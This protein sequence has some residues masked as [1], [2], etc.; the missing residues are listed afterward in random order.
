MK[1]KGNFKDKIIVVVSLAV[2]IISVA[3]LMPKSEE[4]KKEI[5]EVVVLQKEVKENQ[6]IEE[7]D[8]KVV[9]VG[10]YNLPGEV[11]TKKEDAIG[12]YAVTTLK[13]GRYIYKGDVKNEQAMSSY[14]YK[15]KEDSIS[16]QTDLAKCVGG[17]P[18]QG[19]IVRVWIYEKGDMQNT[20]ETK[21]EN[22]PILAAMKLVSIVNSAGAPVAKTTDGK[23]YGNATDKTKPAVVTVL[24][25]V[26]QQ[27][28]IIK[29]QYMGQIHLA[30][31]PR[32]DTVIKE[33]ETLLEGKT[34]SEDLP[35]V[36]GNTNGGTKEA[37]VV[38]TGSQ[39]NDTSQNTSGNSRSA[40]ETSASKDSAK[41]NDNGGSFDIQ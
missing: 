30:L 11:V 17:I 38:Q 19:D 26:S 4:Q 29:G 15:A 22:P 23:D 21:A 35:Q 39:P 27:Q 1:I 9:K 41:Q 25:S 34:V 32:N 40:T 8:V 2:A 13:P 28:A 18:E 36:A 6:G 24:A 16:F 10:K 7:G 33:M 37:A 5:A 12:K 14:L 20:E 3:L 31:R